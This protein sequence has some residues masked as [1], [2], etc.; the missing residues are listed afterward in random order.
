MVTLDLWVWF[1]AQGSMES[2][3]SPQP[4]E[5][6]PWG[7]GQGLKTVFLQGEQWGSPRGPRFVLAWAC[8]TN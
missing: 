7:K 8:V 5:H 1:L 4:Q 6:G 2:Q 3:G